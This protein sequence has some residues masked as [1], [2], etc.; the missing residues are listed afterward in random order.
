MKKNYRQYFWILMTALLII[1]AAVIYM[2]GSGTF[3]FV[4]WL[5]GAVF[6]ALLAFLSGRER[7]KKI[8]KVIRFASYAV[9]TAIAV[10]AMVCFCLMLSHFD[11]RGEKD[12]DYIIVLGAQV[13]NGY[14]S[15]I[16]KYRLDAACDYLE[17][18]PGT[19]CI[20]SGAQG[21]NETVAEG[22]GGKDYLVSRGISED[23]I[24]AE[25][26]ARDTG[27]NARFSLELIL[28]E[29]GTAS[30]TAEGGSPLRIGIVT[31]NFHL[32]RGLYLAEKEAA[33]FTALS[34]GESGQAPEFCGISA[35]TIPMYLPNNMIRECFGIVRDCH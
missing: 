20:V 12:L 11:D 13:R 9:I 7:W 29:S 34:S 30:D 21:Y 4:I 14:P 31:N 8:P 23:R 2:V 17:D 15:T 32:F 18:N 33:E 5:C 10:T 1:Y 22:E 26:N 3:S 35:Y 25:T 28:E 16:F 6:A 27:E 19:I 24:I